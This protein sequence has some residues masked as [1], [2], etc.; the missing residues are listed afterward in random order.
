MK[1]VGY[2]SGLLS[3]FKDQRIIKN[4]E[5]LLLKIIENKTVRILR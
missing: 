4:V 3:F 2:I 1:F 5:Q